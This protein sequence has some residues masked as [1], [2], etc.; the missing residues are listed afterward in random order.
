[1]IDQ[2]CRAGADRQVCYRADGDPSGTPL[3]L[4]AGLTMDLTSWPGAM[5]D[6]LVAQGFYVVRFDNRDVGRTTAAASPP[7]SLLR[8]AL[9]R[10]RRDGYDLA[11]MAG[12]AITVLDQLGIAQ[13]H[14]AGMSMGG[15]IAQTVA[16]RYPARTSSLTSIF[17]TTG[18]KRVGQSAISTLLLLSN[19]GSRTRDEFIRKHVRLMSHLAGTGFPL[20]EAGAA[21]YA[22]GAWDRGLGGCG[23]RRCRT[24]DQCHLQ[25]GRPHRRAGSNLRAHVGDSRRPRPH[26]A[27]QRWACDRGGDHRSPPCHY[28]RHGP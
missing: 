9:R 18:G 16:A 17:S 26:R 15:M 7:P 24:A 23:R 21:E 5:V 8:R 6:G 4:I 2:F 27:P 28:R 13:A 19:P 3:L 22:A 12:D 1:M 14:V 10:P 20:D 11:D 25:V